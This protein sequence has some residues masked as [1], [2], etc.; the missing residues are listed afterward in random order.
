M[1]DSKKQIQSLSPVVIKLDSPDSFGKKLSQL[2]TKGALLAAVGVHITAKQAQVT[3]LPKSMIDEART[4]GI[5]QR[6]IEFDENYGYYGELAKQEQVGIAVLSAEERVAK[7]PAFD[8]VSREIT[9]LHNGIRMARRQGPSKLF[10]T[11]LDQ[12]ATRHFRTLDY[13]GSTQLAAEF[14]GDKLVTTTGQSAMRYTDAKGIRGQLRGE[15]VDE[16]QKQWREIPTPDFART[17]ATLGRISHRQNVIGLKD[18]KIASV[19]LELK[20][21]KIEAKFQDQIPGG[22]KVFGTIVGLLPGNPDIAVSVYT[23]DYAQATVTLNRVD[24]LPAKVQQ[25]LKS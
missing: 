12:G 25:I 1:S 13:S 2:Q 7:S 14:K 24:T 20:D 22:E 6:N 10:S 16:Q 23:N 5:A 4:R 17:N 21:D 15:Q 8:E 18:G 9:K 11:E 19:E 3:M